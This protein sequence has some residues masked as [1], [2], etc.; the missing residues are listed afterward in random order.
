MKKLQCKKC[1]NFV[2][3]RDIEPNYEATKREGMDEVGTDYRSGLW[4]H[5]GC[6][7]EIVEIEIG[8]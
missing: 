3:K 7:G 5:K 8:D 4:R 1:G 2:D 6:G